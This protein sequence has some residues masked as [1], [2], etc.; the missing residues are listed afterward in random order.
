MYST[1]EIVLANLFYNTEYTK[2]VLPYIKIEYFD[3][4]AQKI[5]FKNIEH[6]VNKYNSNP[7]KESLY[8]E[9]SKNKNMT[10]AVQKSVGSTMDTILQVGENQN[11]DW[12]IETTEKFVQ[13]KA[14]HNAI[15]QSIEIFEGK[16]KVNDWGAIPDILN[17]A[18][19]VSFDSSI[20][21]DY[22][23]DS[24][25]RFE[26][27]HAKEYKIPLRLDWFKRITKGGVGKRTLNLMLGP[28]HGGKSAFLINFAADD[29]ADGRNVLYITNEMSEFE[30]SKRIDANLFDVPMDEIQNL[31]REDYVKGINAIRAKSHGR[32]K[33]KEY[34]MAS[35]HV[36][37]Y[38][39]LLNELKLKQNFVPD[40]IYVDYLNIML[41][42]RLKTGA[43]SNMYY[44]VKCISEELRGLASEFDVPIWSA[45]QF[46]RAGAAEEDPGM[47]GVSESFG[48]NFTADLI[49]AIIVTEQMKKVGHV[50]LKQLKNRYDDMNKEPR[51]FIE[52]Q[53]SKM[54]FL[55][56]AIQPSTDEEEDVKS[57]FKT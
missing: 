57:K 55:D 23:D 2:R 36:G 44:Y 27:Y 49:V 3:T 11:L 5:I 51:Q 16:D 17:K 54:K 21:H 20:G 29:L 34:P 26:H 46:N 25:Q 19:S 22:I 28:P 1:E 15:N 18:L 9:I 45:T 30:I 42:S 35:S 32:L 43:S 7:T 31:S 40:V 33:I 39:A 6:Y 48:I 13:K 12:M 8:I 56:L 41:S 47:G 52:F 50:L 53:R 37:H 24:D 4:A 10:E 14:L 38:R